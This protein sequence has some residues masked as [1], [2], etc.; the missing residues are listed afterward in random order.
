MCKFIKA[1]GMVIFY[2][3]F[4]PLFFLFWFVDI[5]INGRPGGSDKFGG[6]K[7][8]PGV[9]YFRGSQTFT[10]VD[11][12]AYFGSIARPSEQDILEAKRRAVKT[13]D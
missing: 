8:I 6:E 4:S 10:I 11:V 12:G 9:R 1:V 7:L 5:V 2:V 13:S 3:V